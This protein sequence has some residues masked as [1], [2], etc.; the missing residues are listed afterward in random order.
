MSL[1]HTLT[2]ALA[3]P[4]AGALLALSLA[5]P[6][7]A[8][9][10][11]TPDTTAA[12]ASAVLT[13]SAGHGCE[14]S[15]T[16]SIEIQI[17][18]EILSVTPTRNPYWDVEKKMVALDEPVTDAHGNTVSERVGSVVYTANDPLPDG[19]RD[20]FDLSLTL[21]DAAGSTLAFPTVQKC[22]QGQTGWIEI[23]AEGQD[24]H[25]LESPA[26]SFTVTAA[27][28]HEGDDADDL[29]DD[30]DADDK[31]D[32]DDGDD[33]DDDGELLGA[34]G[35]GAGVLGALLGGAAL[36]QVRRKS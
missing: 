1:R 22:E 13:F 20:T 33:G 3:G 31:A 19:V 17:P 30:S 8:H 6:A 9:V 29:D 10:T 12:N 34:F 15:P 18:E 14:G 24:P 21:P 4:A 32:S 16:T 23:P 5:G 28:A 11:V 25:E 26:P 2:R 27:V 7:S 36:L 35:L